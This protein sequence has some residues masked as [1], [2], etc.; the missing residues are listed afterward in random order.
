[1]SSKNKSNLS[2]KLNTRAAFKFSVAIIIFV[3]LHHLSSFNPPLCSCLCAFLQLQTSVIV[4]VI[5]PN[6]LTA[7]ECDSKLFCSSGHVVLFFFHNLCLQWCK[8]YM[9]TGFAFPLTQ[10][11]V[12]ALLCEWAISAYGISALLARAPSSANLPTAKAR[13]FTKHNKWKKKKKK[14]KWGTD[15]S[16]NKINY[17]TSLSFSS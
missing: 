5:C 8:W 14:D 16:L 2:R 17:S 1:M 15:Q 6:S 9:F 4:N 13:I 10:H 3:Y 7:T 11:D 12:T